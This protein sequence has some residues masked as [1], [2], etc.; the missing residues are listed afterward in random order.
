M[1]ELRHSKLP[2]TPVG[3][4]ALEIYEIIERT[5][6]LEGCSPT[7]AQIRA[8]IAR[9]TNIEMSSGALQWYIHKLIRANWLTVSERGSRALVPIKQPR[10]Y[11]REA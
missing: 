3:G 9:S 8:E 6:S 10:V 7:Y 1:K 5:Y 4:I 2:F 11:Y